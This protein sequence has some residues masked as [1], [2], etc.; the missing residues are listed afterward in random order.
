[1]RIFGVIPFIK[2]QNDTWQLNGEKRRKMRWRANPFT[3]FEGE[4]FPML[5]GMFMFIFLDR[6]RSLFYQQ[7]NTHDVKKQQQNKTNKKLIEY[8]VTTVQVH[9]SR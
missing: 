1:M 8:R 2:L 5:G 4:Q 3:L 6:E 9:G 7:C